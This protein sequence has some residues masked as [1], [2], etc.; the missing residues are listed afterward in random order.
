MKSNDQEA[1][2]SLSTWTAGGA[3]EDFSSLQLRRERRRSHLRQFWVAL[4][5]IVIVG[6]PGLLAWIQLQDARRST[7]LEEFSNRWHSSESL[8]YRS[9]PQVKR[10]LDEAETART[11]ALKLSDMQ[12]ISELRKALQRLTEAATVDH[13]LQQLRPMHESLG[14]ALTNTPWLETAA[15]ISDKVNTLR[16]QHVE[17]Q[18]MLD[19]GE[20]IKARD[21]LAELLNQLG[22]LQ[23][24]NVLAMNSLASRS[25]WFRA[26]QQIP[27]RL[28][29]EPSIAAIR[30]LGRDAE[31]GWDAGDWTSV[32]MLYQRATERLNEYLNAQLTEEEKSQRQASNIDA[33]TRL[34][35]EKL[36][37]ATRVTKLEKDKQLLS[38]Q[39]ATTNS[40]RLAAEN[41]ALTLTQQSDT[42]AATLSKVSPNVDH[43]KPI[44]QQLQSLL[45]RTTEAENSVAKL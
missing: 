11:E 21:A 12:S 27:E 9:N 6:I 20:T 41:Q 16:Q 44:D 3:A 25:G 17:I 4:G 30:D 5:I 18:S 39:L 37:L 19:I 1:A 24:G 13:D 31:N 8:H 2:Q 10:L 32:S 43:N 29:D 42:I 22:Q 38:E 26:S 45:T 35:G 14:V 7:L 15:V 36:D 23:Q 34:E 28:K 40:Q 33:I